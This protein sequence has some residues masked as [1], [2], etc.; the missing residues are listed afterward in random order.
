MS[1]IKH[2]MGLT[3]YWCDCPHGLQSTWGTG[4]EPSCITYNHEAN[5]CTGNKHTSDH[6]QE[7]AFTNIF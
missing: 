6:S 2:M 7:I 5:L 4:N 3:F 1:N